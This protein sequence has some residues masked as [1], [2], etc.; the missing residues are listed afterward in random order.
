[1]LGGIV[2]LSTFIPKGAFSLNPK[3]INDAVLTGDVEDH[4]GR[5]GEDD[6]SIEKTE[7]PAKAT[8]I[9]AMIG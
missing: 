5:K 3:M 2:F 9:G 6:S 1:V 7:A 4:A 8:D